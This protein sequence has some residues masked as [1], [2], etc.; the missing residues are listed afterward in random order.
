MCV[1]VLG[2]CVCVCV[3]MYWVYVC[4]HVCVHVCDCMCVCVNIV[5]DGDFTKMCIVMNTICYETSQ[6]VYVVLFI[7]YHCEVY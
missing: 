6:H 1:N 7:G 2:V 5:I 3:C 4:V